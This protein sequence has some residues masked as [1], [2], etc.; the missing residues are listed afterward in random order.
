MR[1]VKTYLDTLMDDEGFRGRFA[2]EYERLEALAAKEKGKEKQV[3]KKFID[4][5]KKSCKKTFKSGKPE[6]VWKG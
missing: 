2:H 6:A 5:L 3:T 4:N 1:K